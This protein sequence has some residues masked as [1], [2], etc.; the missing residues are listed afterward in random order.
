MRTLGW[1]S[2]SLEL[3]NIKSLQKLADALY[4]DLISAIK[5]ENFIGEKKVIF[6]AFLLKTLIVG[7]G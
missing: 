5:I 1:Q 2:S 4:S 7:T 3:K 6:L